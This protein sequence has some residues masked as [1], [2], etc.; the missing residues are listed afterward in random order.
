MSYSA[1]L[2]RICSQINNLYDD[3]DILANKIL[4]INTE[5]CRINKGITTLEMAEQ[6]LKDIPAEEV[7]PEPVEQELDIF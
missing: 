3:I 1:S 6:A 7:P 4:D 5:L 2:D